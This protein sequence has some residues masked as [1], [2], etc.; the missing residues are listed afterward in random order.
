MNEPRVG[1]WMVGAFGG[2]GTTAA[3]GLAALSRGLIDGTGLVT[4]LPLCAGLDL[5]PPSR[6]VVG[7]HDVRRTSFRQAVRE[8][9]QRAGVFEEEIIEACGPDLAAW[10]EN[11]RPGTVLHTGATIARLADLP[12]AQRQESVRATIERLQADLRQFRE[13]QRLDQVVVLNVASTEPPFPVDE[14]HSSLER[15]LERRRSGGKAVLPASALYA[16]AALDLGMPYLNFT[17][18]LGSSLPALEELA[19][20]RKTVHGGKDGK[21]GETLLKT[22]LAPMFAQRN[23][24]VLELG[25]TQHPGQP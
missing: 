3:L 14:A 16:W 15:L 5:D 7:G 12:E 11:V 13:G 21:T 23:F 20:Q 9:H 19:V 17:P 6:F 25:G 24:Q 8:M 1:L 18:S 4:A 2:V 10:S 22:V